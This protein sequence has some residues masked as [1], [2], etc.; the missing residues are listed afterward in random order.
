MSRA[1][2]GPQRMLLCIDNN[3]SILEY[4]RSLFERSGYVV[5]T[6]LSA[7]QGLKLAMMFRFDAVL[8]D[9]QMSGMNGHRLAFEMRHVRPDIPVVMFS[10]G[11]IPEET[12]NLVDAVV[13]RTKALDE[14]LPAVARICDQS[15]Q[16]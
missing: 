3:Q 9:Y 13:T 4:E 6:A 11:E 8:L 1:Y 7:L 12:R 16:V 2:R 14:L 15:S 5:I 10:S